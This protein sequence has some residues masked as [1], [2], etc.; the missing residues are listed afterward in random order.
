MLYRE[1]DL[2]R[3]AEL[4]RLRDEIGK[5]D[6]DVEASKVAVERA[7]KAEEGSKKK[8]V[9]AVQALESSWAEKVELVKEAGKCKKE[10]TRLKE[11]NSRLQT[12]VEN[13]CHLQTKDVKQFLDSAEGVGP[14][15]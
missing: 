9:E 10:G 6:A 4:W 1:K 2:V 5:K 15:K 14:G 11:E 13:A 12:A 3:V 7:T 8:R